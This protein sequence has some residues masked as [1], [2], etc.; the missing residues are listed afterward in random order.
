MFQADVFRLAGL[1]I[2]HHR[3]EGDAGG[4]K[5]VA[6][7]GV[8]LA[9]DLVIGVFRVHDV[10]GFQQG[11]QAHVVMVGI[12]ALVVADDPSRLAGKIVNAEGGPGGHADDAVKADAGAVK[13][14]QRPG[15]E[16]APHGAAL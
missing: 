6:V 5:G 12:E 8:Q 10:A 14:I 13:N 16:H 9:G 3:P 11:D 2:G 1:H 7:E 4:V 15:G